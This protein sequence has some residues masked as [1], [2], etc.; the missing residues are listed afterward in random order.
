MARPHGR[1]R[2][3]PKSPAAFGICDRCGF[4]YNH[5]DL[6]WQF[7]WGGASL[8]NKRILVCTPCNDK[9]QNQLRAIVLPADPIP[10]L[11]PRVELY[12]EAETD[13]RVVITGSYVDPITGLTVQTYETRVTED[14]NTRV[15]Q[16]IGPPQGYDSNA[17]MPLYGNVQ[18]GYKLPVISMVSDGYETITVT[19]SYAH[20]LVTGSQV[21][22]EGTT[23]PQSSGFFSVN[24]VSATV[25]TYYIQSPQPSGSVLGSSTVIKTVIVGLPYGMTTLPKTGQ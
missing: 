23:T 15:E 5:R 24:V 20:G 6:M 10:I 7:D 22:V 19:C 18:F 17:V 16:E 8:I 13:T 14:G 12:S 2:V 9:P 25:F 3:N 4:L 1:A 11:N 21:S